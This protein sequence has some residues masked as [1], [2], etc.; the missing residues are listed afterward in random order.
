[1][2]EHV[3]RRAR[4]RQRIRNNPIGPVLERYVAYLVDRGHGLAP[5]HQYVFAAEHFGR[6]LGRRS[7]R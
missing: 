4:V 1:M 3:F 2:L 7:G 6:W 5:V